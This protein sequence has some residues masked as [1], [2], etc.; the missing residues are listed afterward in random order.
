[1][2]LSTP[3][4]AAG[5]RDVERLGAALPPPGPAVRAV[6]VVPAHDEERRIGACLAALAAQVEIAPAAF[7]IVVVLDAC[8]DDTAA[9]VGAAR[10][11]LD[12]AIHV[13]AGPGQGAGPARATGMDVGCARLESLGRR[14]GLLASTDADSTVAPDWIASWRRSPAG[15]RRSAAR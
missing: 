13:V 3:D 6:V 5:R 2:G 8:T 7:E 4:R 11:D 12:P 9:V 15:P 1:V 10:A 14:D